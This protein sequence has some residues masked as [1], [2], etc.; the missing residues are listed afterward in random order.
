MCFFWDRP[1]SKHRS[2]FYIL[3]DFMWPRNKPVASSEKIQQTSAA[4]SDPLRPRLASA[5][6]SCVSRDDSVER[7]FHVGYLCFLRNMSENLPQKS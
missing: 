5:S 4:K 7:L 2:D 3:C 6:A 1:Y